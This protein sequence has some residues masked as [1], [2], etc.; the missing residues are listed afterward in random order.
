M[1]PVRGGA[2]TSGNTESCGCLNVEQITARST[3]HG[4]KRVGKETPEYRSYRAAKS[5]CTNPHDKHYADYGGRGIR[6]ELPPFIEFYS[7]LG[8]RPPQCS[9]DRFPDN[10]GHYKLGNVRWATWK[11]QAANSRPKKNALPWEEIRALRAA[12]VTVK[13]IAKKLNIWETVLYANTKGLV[14]KRTTKRTHCKNGH[15]RTP[16]NVSPKSKNCKIC[17]SAAYRRSECR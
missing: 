12:G 5:R 14:A 9:L 2:L 13:E 8:P 17:M 1:L 10:N 3:I 11:E 7:A 15:P 6:F 16:E 4:H